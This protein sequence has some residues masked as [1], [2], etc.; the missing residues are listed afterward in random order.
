MA[1]KFLKTQQ[2]EKQVNTKPPNFYKSFHFKTNV[3]PKLFI[4]K[5]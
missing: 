3:W 2:Q 4:L 1:E 5:V